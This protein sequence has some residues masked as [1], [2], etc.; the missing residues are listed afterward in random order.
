M[1]GSRTLMSWDVP[2]KSLERL[3][4][5]K[6]LW[7][8]LGDKSTQQKTSPKQGLNYKDKLIQII[9]EMTLRPQLYRWSLFS[10]MVSVHT[11]IRPSVTKNRLQH[12]KQ[13]TL[14][15]CMGP[16]GSLNSPDLFLN[17]TSTKSLQTRIFDVE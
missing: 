13:N 9:T 11:F 2:L 6:E 15:R 5:T 17:L 1:N 10:H 3:K 16:G 7:P 12:H 14:E 8:N 4:K